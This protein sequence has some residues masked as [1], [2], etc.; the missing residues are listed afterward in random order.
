[1]PSR[2]HGENIGSRPQLVLEGLGSGEGESLWPCV[3]LGLE[4]ARAELLAL[5]AG[6][7]G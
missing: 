2:E 3:G 7:E 5:A 6:D 1:M 4:L